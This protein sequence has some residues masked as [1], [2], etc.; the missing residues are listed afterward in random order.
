MDI[1]VLGNVSR[2]TYNSVNRL[3]QAKFEQQNPDDHNWNNFDVDFSVK[4]GD[5]ED[6]SKAYDANGNIKRMQ[7]WAY[8][9][10]ALCN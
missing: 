3:M 4:M 5:G 6:V 7:Q 2:I 10:A 1:G 8:N 9:L